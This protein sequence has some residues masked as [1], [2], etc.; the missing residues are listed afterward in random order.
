MKFFQML[1]LFLFALF[2]I[3]T[4]QTYAQVYPGQVSFGKVPV[5]KNHYQEEYNF[6]TV[7][8]AAAWKSVTRGLNVGFATTD[9]LFFRSEVPEMSQS[10]MSL[11]ATSWKNERVNAQ[12]LIWSPDTINHIRVRA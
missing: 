4:T 3:F 8:N 10:S 7:V 11:E 6:D 12:L 1:R 5:P 2:C 9:E